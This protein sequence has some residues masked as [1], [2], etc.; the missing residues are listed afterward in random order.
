MNPNTSVVSSS[1]KLIFKLILCMVKSLISELKYIFHKSSKRAQAISY[2]VNEII[3]RNVH[4]LLLTAYSACA[5][6]K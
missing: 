1:P 4:V 2:F 3:L 5:V 6:Q